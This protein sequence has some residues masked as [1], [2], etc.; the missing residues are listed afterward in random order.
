MLTPEG[1]RARQERLLRALRGTGVSACVISR[2]KTIYYFCGALV[3]STWPQ[4]LVL[5]G[6]GEWT[7]V[8][9][10]QPSVQPSAQVRTYTGYTLE[11]AFG[12]ESGHAELAGIV[13]GL[14]LPA[15]IGVEEE[16]I[17]GGLLT[18]FG[19]TVYNL[20]PVIMEMRRRKDPDEL[21]CMR[22]TTRLTEA[23]YRAIKQRLE[24]GMTEYE[25]Y[26]TIES[27]IVAAAGTSVD[28]KGDFACGL[29]AI[30]GGGPPTGKRI[31]RGELYIFDLF[32]IF[33][34]YMC[35]LCRTFAVGDPS[36][37]Q[38]QAWAHVLAAHDIARRVI[39][40]GVS[41]SSV[42]H[43]VRTYLERYVSTRGSFTHHLGHGVGMDGWEQP[44]INA[45]S[46]QVFIEGE[47][48]ACEPGLYSVSLGGGIRLEHNYLVT[49]G[50]PVPLDEF[51]M[52]L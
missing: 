24:P 29:R 44:W 5:D 40:P 41:T 25:A 8:T 51:P 9:N 31:E 52:D 15:R 34:G 42:Y 26:S 30:G 49:A 36:A 3:D 14:V 38:Q 21:E 4:A 43:E 17:S 10:S 1:C 2:P 6:N 7:L 18:R 45:G 22:R 33:E 39:R 46:D 11:R 19:G 16:W 35:D 37:E 48:V 12:R 23:G 20:T 28:L 50:G 13:C 47:V 27:A 32:P